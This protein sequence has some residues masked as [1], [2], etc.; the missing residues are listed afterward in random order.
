MW[1]FKKAKGDLIGE[2]PPAPAVQAPAERKREYEKGAQ[3]YYPIDGT[4]ECHVFG[5]GEVKNYKEFRSG[6]FYLIM[7]YPADAN[8]MYKLIEVEE[9]YLYPKGGPTQDS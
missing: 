5:L 2:Y 6:W 8:S 3:V 1:P 7:P 9:L 4:D